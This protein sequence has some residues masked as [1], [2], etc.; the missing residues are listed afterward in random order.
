M[1]DL[2][3]KIENST[4]IVLS[5]GESFYY[6]QSYIQV[7]NMYLRPLLLDFN[8]I[9]N[10]SREILGDAKYKRPFAYHD[11]QGLNVF[12]PTV[13]SKSKYCIFI[14]LH[15]LSCHNVKE[16]NECYGQFISNHTWNTMIG[17]AISYRNM[18][19]DHL[20]IPFNSIKI[21][22]ENIKKYVSH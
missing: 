13:S 10:A 2:I 18:F 4:V 12:I 14:S 17:M 15:Y 16:F 21:E 8:T 19:N 20:E 1:I 11:D 5:N 22:K 9:L 7:M 6:E 3:F